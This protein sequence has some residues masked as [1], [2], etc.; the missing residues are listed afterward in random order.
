MKFIDC[1]LHLDPQSPKCAKEQV[2]EIVEQMGQLG[3]ELG[4]LIHLNW[5]RFSVSEIALSVS[6]TTKLITVV[7]I[8]PTSTG[9]LASLELA[10][11]DYN[12]QGLKLHP[13]FNRFDI[14]G[15]KTFEICQRAGELGVPVIVCAFPDGLY[16]ERGLKATQYYNL[17]RSCPETKF[18]WAHMG[19]HKV[20]DFVM[21]ARTLK[22][23]Y[24]DFSLTL[25]YYNNSSV[26]QDLVY[27]MKN[28]KY[29]RV[30]YGSDYPDRPLNESFNMSL[31]T[32]E[33]LEVPE[34]ALKKL[35]FDNA[36]ILFREK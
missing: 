4:V 12:F 15:Q 2:A 10:V 18:V 6:D 11:R 34:Y 16:L 21:L 30:F 29:E 23:V 26:Q 28:L 1:H 7:N 36:A 24:M 9:A 13:R 3:C 20:L 19:G 35:Y 8:D 32:L 31:R 27:A 5:Q 33:S 22:N 14:T 17:A 25:T